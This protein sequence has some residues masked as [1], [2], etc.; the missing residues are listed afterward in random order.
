MGFQTHLLQKANDRDM[1]FPQVF[2][3]LF[4]SLF[5]SQLSN[6]SVPPLLPQTLLQ[7]L[8]T[9]LCIM[10][11]TVYIRYLELSLATPGI[12]VAQALLLLRK[13]CSESCIMSND[14]TARIVAFSE[15]DGKDC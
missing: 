2:P 10:L 7:S 15:P 12:I 5:S 6:S 1:N 11:D 13:G 3:W 4:E 9:L 14:V 8:K